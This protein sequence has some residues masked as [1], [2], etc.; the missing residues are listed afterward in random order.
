MST[1]SSSARRNGQSYL[2]NTTFST[3]TSITCKLWRPQ[4]IQKFISNGK[5]LAGYSGAFLTSLTLERAG[6][7]E[8]RIRQL[9]M[10]L[11]YVE[12]LKISHPFVKG[13]EQVHYCISE[14]E[15]KSVAQGDVSE[16]VLKRKKT[17]TEGKQETLVCY[18]T[19]FYIGI[20]VEAKQS[21]S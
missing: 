13:F 3:D 21:M 20:E 16:A 7:V 1:V 19:T 17:D 11:E 6:T 2:P 10:K 12:A 8:S 15:L 14:D 9:V 5:A 18:T 4:V